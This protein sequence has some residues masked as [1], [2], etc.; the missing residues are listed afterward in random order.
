MLCALLA[1]LHLETHFVHTIP[2]ND[3]PFLLKCSPKIPYNVYEALR[4]TDTRCYC[5]YCNMSGKSGSVLA[6]IV[7]TVTCL[8]K[9]GWYSLLLCLL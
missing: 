9:V 3:V 1:P 4:Q 5:V 6:V 7:F 2:W 8:E